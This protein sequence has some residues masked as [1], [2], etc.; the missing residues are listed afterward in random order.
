MGSRPASATSGRE[1]ARTVLSGHAVAASD[2]SKPVSELREAARDARVEKSP[3]ARTRSAA[4]RVE[5]HKKFALSAAFVVLAVVGLVN[6]RSA[7]NGH[8][9]LVIA[10]SCLVDVVYFVLLTSGETLAEARV[11]SPAIGVRSANVL[12]LAAALLLGWRRAN[13]TRLRR[14]LD[15][16]A[17]RVSVRAAHARP[18]S[19]NRQ[20]MA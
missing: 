8:P 18:R 15:G 10:A 2:R 19:R 20:L 3:G 16:S 11:M 12:L 4:F 9:G 13:R 14:S 17:P 6:A 1:A 7:P 5:I